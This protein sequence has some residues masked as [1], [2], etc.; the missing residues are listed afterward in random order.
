M[1]LI[2]FKK[3]ESASLSP[4][5]VHKSKEEKAC[6]ITWQIVFSTTNLEPVKVT[7]LSESDYDSTESDSKTSGLA[8]KMDVKWLMCLGNK[9]YI[10]ATDED[11]IDETNYF[12]EGN[13]MNHD[14]NE[15]MKKKQSA[16]QMCA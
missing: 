1:H 6:E 4:A 16:K 11:L 12:V 14:S 9:T 5:R 2:H 3:I 10:N 7:Y 8:V 13:V 15:N